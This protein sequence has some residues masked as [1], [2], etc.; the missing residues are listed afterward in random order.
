MSGYDSASSEERFYHKRVRGK[1]ARRKSISDVRA[2]RDGVPDLLSVRK[3]PAAAGKG[4]SRTTSANSP[5]SSSTSGAHGSQDIQDMILGLPSDTHNDY[6]VSLAKAAKTGEQVADGLP[7][8]S[9]HKR[10]LLVASD[11]SGIASECPALTRLGVQ[12]EKVFSSEKNPSK[13]AFMREMH[14]HYKLKGKVFEDMQDRD[15]NKLEKCDFYIAGPPCQPFS[16]AGENLALGDLKERGVVIF[17]CVEYIVVQRPRC[18]LIENVWNLVARHPHYMHLVVRLLESAGYKV[19][20]GKM[21]TSDS[22]LP[23]ARARVYICGIRLDC[24]THEFAMPPPLPWKPKLWDGFVDVD[25]VDEEFTLSGASATF[26]RNYKYAKK[27]AKKHGK[28]F[29]K[30]PRCHIECASCACAGVFVCST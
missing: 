4:E 27:Y 22:C 9:Q 11:C 12:F 28:D 23:H 26:K 18:F 30:E 8:T 1:L 16:Q 5:S 29:D 10:I 13:R 19:V 7:R 21:E 3:R 14:R 15:V 6:L 2:N 25:K 20:W 24:E 17:Y